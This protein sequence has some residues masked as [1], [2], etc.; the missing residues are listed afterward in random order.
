MAELNVNQ[1]NFLWPEE[2]KLFKHILVL[3]KQTLPYEE[4][5]RGTFSREYFSDYIMPVVPHTPWEFKNIPIPPGIRQKVIEFLKSKIDAG[6][7]EASQSSYCSRWFCILK[8]SGA[9][10]LIH[11]LQ[12]LN[13]ITIRDAGQIPEPDD[14]IEPYGGCQCYTM[15][16]MFWGFD[17]RK[18]DLD[19]RDLTAFY[20]PLG[21]LRI[22]A[23]PMG[24][25][26]SPAEFQNCMIFILKDEIPHVANIFI[27]DLPIRGPRTQYLDNQGQPKVLAENP[28]IRKFI[29]EHA[30]D[31][32]RIMHCIKCAGGT[33]LPK[34]TQICRP[35][36]V[37]LGQKCSA[38]GCHPEDARVEKILKWPPLKSVTA[39]QGFLG[40]CGTVRIWIKDYSKIAHPLVDLVR[41]DFEFNWGEKQIEAFQMLKSKVSTSPALQ[42]IDYTSLRPAYLSVNTSQKAVGFILSQED[43]HGRRRPARYGSIPL[44]ERESRYSQPKLE[45]YGLFRALH[46]WRKYIIGLNNFHVEVDAKYIKGMLIAPDMQPNAAINRWIQG[47]LLFDFNLIHVP[48]TKFKGPDAL[49]QRDLGPEEEPPAPEYD[50]SWLDDMAL[51]AY[52][53]DM[54]VA[55]DINSFI[56]QIEHHNTI[57][58]SFVNHIDRWQIQNE[59][60]KKIKELHMHK[61]E[62]TVTNPRGHQKFL[63]KA[64]QFYLTDDGC[65]FKRNGDRSPLLVVLDQETWTKILTEAHDRLGHKGEQAVY[66]I[67]RLRVFWPLL[68]TDIH[69]HVSSCQECQQR[70]LQHMVLPPTVSAPATIFEKVYI[71]IMFMPMSDGYKYIVCAKDDLTGVVEASALKRNK[72]KELAKFLWTKIYC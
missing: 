53:P 18:V 56:Y 11:D 64:S 16:D 13:K 36:V 8:K 7:Y 40:L 20:T 2:E 5:D 66:D 68:R 55:Q 37:I 52:Q 3:N 25:T 4:K 45:L 12:P 32:H 59:T 42:S 21:L 63:K 43:E 58:R 41:K 51:L 38:E 23:L 60:L 49:S 33:F 27:D 62:P 24:Y 46:A 9:L 48:G 29:W 19:S 70:R 72:A 65:L 39:T 15:F 69:H 26:N 31:V 30:N 6:V 50:D 57:V 10:R 54:A 1:D 35:S 44:N 17:A 14:F 67:L 47:I 61:Q 22:T 28:G 34:K 71:D